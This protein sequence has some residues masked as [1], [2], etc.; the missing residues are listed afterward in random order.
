MASITPDFAVQ[1]Y[2]FRT[3]KDNAA[4]AKA[5]KEIGLDKIEVC[6]VHCDFNKPETFDGVIDTYKQAGV[7]IVSIG[8]EGMNGD[9]AEMTKRFD[10]AKAAGIKHIS[11]NFAPATFDKAHPI[12]QKLAEKYDVR[13]GIHN[14]GG[15]HWLG[16]TEIL[17]YVFSKVG[18]RI[19]LCLDTA[20]ALAA[21]QNPIK[22]VEDFGSRLWAVH[23]KDFVFHGPTGKHEDVIVGTG[24][25]KLPE[26]IGALDAAGFKGQAIMEYEGDPDN[27][28]PTLTKCVTAIRGAL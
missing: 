20:W 24:N 9:E 5:V 2:C 25:L 26:F 18:D 11:V 14:H 16:S 8:V 17:K 27:P 23:M 6:A 7:Q 15:Y 4:V 12:V 1:S 21:W 10:F 13:C 22:M 28:V 3:I 19:G